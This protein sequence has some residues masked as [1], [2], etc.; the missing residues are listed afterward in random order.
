MERL[1]DIHCHILPAVDNGSVS[2]DQTK[3]MLNIAYEEGITYIIATPHYGAGCIN[4]GNPELEDKLEKVRKAAK[5]IDPAFQIEL[6]NEL[7]YSREIVEH[8]RKGRAL[9]L[10]NTRYCLVK[11]PKD[12]EYP[13]MKAGLHSL[14]IQG[15]YPILSHMESYRCLYENYEGIANLINL[16]VYMQMNS[17]SLTGNPLDSRVRY[18]RRLISNGMVHLIGTGSHSDCL[19]PPQMKKGLALIKKDYGEAV[20]KRLLENTQKLLLNQKMERKIFPY[21]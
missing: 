8:L 10:A 2:M 6:G 19:K 4:T 5:E 11:F 12:E 21:A 18:A 13:A 17:R 20:R 7:F 16:G 15:Y 9:T 1:I 3:R 14:L